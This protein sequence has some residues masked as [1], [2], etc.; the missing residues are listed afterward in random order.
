[1]YEHCSRNKI[2]HKKVG[3]LVVAGHNCVDFD[4]LTGGAKVAGKVPQY[5]FAPKTVPWWIQSAEI[6][7]QRQHRN[8]PLN[9]PQ[10]QVNVQTHPELADHVI[11]EEPIMPAAGFI[12]MVRSLLGLCFLQILTA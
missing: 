3:K 10:L 2:P 5:P 4:A 11:K 7:R 9:Y 1:M 8:G 6:A 12:E